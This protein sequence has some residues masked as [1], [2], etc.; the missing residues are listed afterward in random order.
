MEVVAMK[1][2]ITTVLAIFLILPACSFAQPASPPP[3]ESPL[4]QSLLDKTRERESQLRS[5]RVECETTI[6]RPG[7]WMAT[8]AGVV[9]TYPRDPAGTS[10]KLIWAGERYFHEIAT[11]RRNGSGDTRRMAFDGQSQRI[12]DTVTRGGIVQRSRIEPRGEC[13]DTLDGLF[14]IGTGVSAFLEKCEIQVIEQIVIHGR[15]GVRLKVSSPDGPGGPG[16]VV[17]I[18][19][20]LERGAVPV[21][22]ETYDPEFSE[23]HPKRIDDVLELSEIAEG[24]FL[25]ARASTVTYKK[26]D[27]YI[28]EDMVRN[29]EVKDATVNVDLG[30]GDFTFEFPANTTIDDRTAPRRR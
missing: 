6:E 15:E 21:R 19:F 28:T 2:R 10:E 22:V 11:R 8:A 4:L 3:G 25:P 29:V 17:I 13:L 18:E 23:G 16:H 12:Y 26:V 24:I 5:F 14:L 9:R 30:K 7:D 27:I 1:C 20:D